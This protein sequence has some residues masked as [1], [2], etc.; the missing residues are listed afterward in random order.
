MLDVDAVRRHLHHLDLA[1]YA[2]LA[3]PLR[4]YAQYYGIDM[5]QQLPGVRQYMGWFEAPGYQLA[6]HV[7]MP[8]V[9]KGTLFILHGYLDHAG[10]Y[11]HLIRDALMQQHAVFIFDLPGH[12]FSSGERVDIDDFADY[13]M[14]LEAALAQYGP[15]LPTPFYALGQ[16]TGGAILMDHVLSAYARGEAPAFARML[17]LA[18]LLRPAQWQRIRFGYGLMHRLQSSV[19]RVF[20]NNSSDADFL[21]FVREQDPL[22]A[23]RVP[24]RWIGALKR[25]VA[26]MQVLPACDFPVLLVQGEKDGTVEWRG[27]VDY[28]RRHFRV[29]HEALLPAASHHL[30]NERADLRAS[31]HAALARLL[32]SPAN[33]AALPGGGRLSQDDWREA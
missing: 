33:E 1:V 30:A 24:M 25:W 19:P 22:Q 10:L 7:F 26:H 28:V 17:L 5:E 16:S 27:N 4:A 6:G 2:P 32:A 29:V 13:Q 11:G 23:H 3:G 12:G 14:V 21:R 8:T 18:P 31:V 9:A 15:D 20:R